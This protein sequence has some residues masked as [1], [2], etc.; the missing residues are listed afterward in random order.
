MQNLFDMQ[1]D[2]LT[3]FL[4]QLITKINT[5]DELQ[6]TLNNDIYVTEAHKKLNQDFCARNNESMANFQRMLA[7]DETSFLCS[8]FAAI[9]RQSPTSET[10]K[11]LDKKHGL[12]N[13]LMDTLVSKRDDF[14]TGAKFGSFAVTV[15]FVLNL[16]LLKISFT[17]NWSP[18]FKIVITLVIIGCLYAYYCTYNFSEYEK[19]IA[20]ARKDRDA[21]SAKMDKESLPYLK[22]MFA[23]AH[24][25]W[26]NDPHNVQIMQDAET[27]TAKARDQL[28]AI[29][30][31][32]IRNIPSKF[33]SLY[34]L[35]LFESYLQDGRA[36]SW[37]ECVNLY[38]QEVQFDESV[39]HHREEEEHNRQQSE[40][41]QQELWEQQ[42]QSNIQEQQLNEDLKQSTLQQQQLDEVANQSKTQREQLKE[43][44][45]QTASQGKQ[46]NELQKHTQLGK[47]IGASS[48]LQNVQLNNIHN[49]QKNHDRWVEKGFRT[50]AEEEQYRRAHPKWSRTHPRQGYY[51]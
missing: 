40:L 46:L 32:E 19:K 23:K 10:Y 22:K 34:F 43:A 12:L 5:R 31:D 17:D 45:K 9:F 21:V 15:I 8:N 42:R 2:E 18:L 24:D 14:Q 37:K 3:S 51:R 33:R 38:H 7:G 30:L 48:V 1:R 49:E 28:A 44:R 41:Q 6:R 29:N 35:S 47:V 16:V 13:Q 27:Q 25:E 4:N 39:R 20:R 11:L 50:K 26:E 36:D